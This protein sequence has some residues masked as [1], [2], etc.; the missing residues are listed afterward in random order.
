MSASYP[1]GQV[2]MS[3]MNPQQFQEFINNL[4]KQYQ[5][6]HTGAQPIPFN[7]N[8]KIQPMP[9][10]INVTFSISTGQNINFPCSPNIPINDLIQRFLT[11]QNISIPIDL[12]GKYQLLF[13]YNAQN[14]LKKNNRTIKE[15]GIT[16]GSKISVTDC[17]NLIGGK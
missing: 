10:D 9:G 7:G 13:T 11:S 16:S 4:Y 17:S 1:T 12:L 6:Q 3:N 5:S 15:L 8:Q 14:L 2:D